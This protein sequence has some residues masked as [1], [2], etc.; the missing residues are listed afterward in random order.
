MVIDYGCSF[1]VLAQRCAV[2]TLEQQQPPVRQGT[3]LS[4]TRGVRARSS[5]CWDARTERQVSCGL[6]TRN[7]RSQALERGQ[8]LGARGQL[9]RKG[10][11]AIVACPLPCQHQRTPVGGRRRRHVRFHVQIYRRVR[12]C[13]R[14][15]I[16]SAQGLSRKPVVHVAAH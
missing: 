15:Q 12:K 3:L 14:G 13:A 11:C 10:C 2:H 9:G 4:S 7:R 5:G 8:G 16:D 1:T 6:A